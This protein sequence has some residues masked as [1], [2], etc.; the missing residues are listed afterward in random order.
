MDKHSLTS[1]NPI[2][3]RY[4]IVS[5]GPSIVM[6]RASMFIRTYRAGFLLSY[7]CLKLVIHLSNKDITVYSISIPKSSALLDNTSKCDKTSRLVRS[8]LKLT[9]YSC[10]DVK[11]LIL[12]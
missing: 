9:T 7:S 3:M 12:L 8:N 4:S 5:T 11:T 10:V 2:I 1:D 6:L